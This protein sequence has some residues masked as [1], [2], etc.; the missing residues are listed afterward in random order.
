[1][2]YLVNL[3]WFANEKISI[4]KSQNYKFLGQEKPLFYP[5]L[6]QPDRNYNFMI[7]L[8]I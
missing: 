4:I 5:N 3:F 6:F 2:L 1:M 7:N 8:N